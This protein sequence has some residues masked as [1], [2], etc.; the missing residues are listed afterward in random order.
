VPKVAQ[1][2]NG[3]TIAGHH[4]HLA[5]PVRTCLHLGVRVRLV[6]FGE[7]WRNGVV[8]HF[9]DILDKRFFRTERFRD[10]LHLAR[11]AG[12]FE[13]FHNAQHQY[14]ALKGATPEEWERRMRFVPTPLDPEVALPMELPRSGVVEFI[15]LVRS[16]RVVRILG[17]KITVPEAFVHRYLTATLYLRTRRLVIDC[18]G[19]RMEMPFPLSPLSERCPATSNPS[20]PGTMCCH[21]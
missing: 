5:L 6:P 2:D 18:G 19:S 14:S 15:P 12:E 1:F 4:R 11:R 21:V 20:Q 17:A 10:L 13:A 16:D 3:Q 8:E 9:N 7:P